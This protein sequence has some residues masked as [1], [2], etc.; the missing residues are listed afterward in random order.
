MVLSGLTLALC[1]DL[2][3]LAVT[4]RL[5]N[6]CFQSKRDFIHRNFGN[7]QQILGTTGTKWHLREKLYLKLSGIIIS[8]NSV[9]IYKF[10]YQEKLVASLS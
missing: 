2:V 1:L 10:G 7:A 3:A 9:K 5:L 4:Y 8:K 6:E